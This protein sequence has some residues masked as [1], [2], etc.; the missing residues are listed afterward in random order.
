MKRA[1]IAIGIVGL[2]AVAGVWR[3][4]SHGGPRLI[5]GVAP[6]KDSG[7]MANAEVPVETLTTPVGDEVRTPAEAQALAPPRPAESV[8]Q[9]LAQLRESAGPIALEGQLYR[10]VPK[11]EL[12]QVV[13]R[14]EDLIYQATKDEM[15]YRFAARIGVET[16]STDPDFHYRGEG[17]DPKAVYWVRFT[18]GGPTEKVTLPQ[19]EFPEIY[20]LKA[21]SAALREEIHSRGSRGE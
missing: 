8:A 13:D 10:D 11:A 21:L 3:A 20:E 4:L 6:Q 7:P 1:S 14:I 2:L 9:K 5:S 19:D 16:L 15:E 17:Y 12:E 18:P